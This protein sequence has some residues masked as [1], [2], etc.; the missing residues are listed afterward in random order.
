V[1]EA[2]GFR[3][4]VNLD[5]RRA[6]IFVG[7]FTLLIVVGALVALVPGVPVVQVLVGVQVLNGMLLPVILLFILILANDR[8]LTGG[9]RTGRVSQLLGWGTFVLVTCAVSVLLGSQILGLFGIS[10]LGG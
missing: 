3:K 9:L 6:P 10:V 4:G 8:R 2:F 7:L 1:S 5:F